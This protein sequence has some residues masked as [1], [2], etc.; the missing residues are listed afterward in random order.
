MTMLDELLG[1]AAR[2]WRPPLEVGAYL[3]P[4]TS[5]GRVSL[6]PALSVE[7]RLTW[8]A[9]VFAALHPGLPVYRLTV[10][11]RL[12]CYLVAQ[13]G[14]LWAWPLPDDP[15]DSTEWIRRER[16]RSIP[17]VDDPA[18]RLHVPVIR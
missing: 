13:S 8:G 9:A 1:W 4:W 6:A 15:L 14:A 17:P 16:F 12:W 11:D 18:L 5:R 3:A 2:P 7:D 10:R